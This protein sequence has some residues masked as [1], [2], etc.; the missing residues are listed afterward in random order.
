MKKKV[1][2]IKKEIGYVKQSPRCANCKHYNEFI[3]NKMMGAFYKQ[4]IIH[5]ECKL[6]NFATKPNA[7]CDHW[8]HK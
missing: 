1:D 5:R 2:E 7:F 4:R 8:E 6:F 3:E